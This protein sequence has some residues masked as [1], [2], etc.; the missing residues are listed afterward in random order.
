[1]R[2][3]YIDGNCETQ[4]GLEAPAL[5][6]SVP[7]QAVQLFPLQRIS[8]VVVSGGVQWHTAALLACADQGI[9]VTFLADGG[10]VAARWLGKGGERQCAMQRLADLMACADGKDCYE[11]WYQAMER[12]VVQ[13]AAKSLLKNPDV[14]VTRDE[15]QAF[16]GEQQENLPVQPFKQIHNTVRGLLS[17]HVMELFQNSGLDAGSELLQEQWLDLPSDFVQL[18]LWDFQVPLLLWLE[19]QVACPDYRQRV[20]F[21]DSRARRIDRLYQGLMNKLQRWLVELF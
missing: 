13:S 4:V 21:Y 8:R 10:T 20:E 17:A 16:L 18:L 14:V 5:K 19:S 6:V 3:L 12:M 1:M 2:P 15:L 7:E 11:N 9:T